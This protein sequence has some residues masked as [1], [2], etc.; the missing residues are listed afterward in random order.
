M[1]KRGSVLRCWPRWLGAGALLLLTAA[2]CATRGPQCQFA[3]SNVGEDEMRDVILKAANGV[4]Y[5]S[6]AI[7]SQAE[8]NYRPTPLRVGDAATLTWKAPDGASFART[9]AIVKPVVK[10]FRGRIVYERDATNT[11]TAFVMPSR[12]K[13]DVILPWGRPE[14][15]EGTVAVPG[16]TPEEGR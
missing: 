10:G 13:D 2:G 9:V 11:V 14:S 4:T 5:R 15:W 8:A 7:P 3:V 16:L 6:G 12:T 1:K